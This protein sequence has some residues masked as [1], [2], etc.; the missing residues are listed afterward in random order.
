M[1]CGESENEI[2][3]QVA[4]EMKHIIKTTALS[5]P[6]FD[7]IVMLKRDRN[8]MPETEAI[9]YYIRNALAHGSFEFVSQRNDVEAYYLL[10]SKQKNTVKAQM[11]LK[12]STMLKLVAF[13]GK[14]AV[15]LNGKGAE[16]TVAGADEVLRVAVL[17]RAVLPADKKRGEV[18]VFLPAEIIHGDLI[19]PDGAGDHAPGKAGMHIGSHELGC[20]AAENSLHED[21]SRHCAVQKAHG[22]VAHGGIVTSSSHRYLSPPDRVGVV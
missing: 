15:F 4:R 12:E 6:N 5:D 22:A 14:T 8:E 18:I 13:D 11:R 7:V 3:R 10:E 16:Q 17:Q 20:A 1:L 21:P 19:A 2:K 9:Y